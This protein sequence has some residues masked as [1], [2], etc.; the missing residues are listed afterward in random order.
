MTLLSSNQIGLSN[1]H[2]CI[3]LS[4]KGNCTNFRLR[5]VRGRLQ[6][7]E[8]NIHMLIPGVNITIVCIK[9]YIVPK[10]LAKFIKHLFYKCFVPVRLFLSKNRLWTSQEKL[11]SLSLLY[12]LNSFREACKDYCS[13]E[14]GS[15]F[16]QYSN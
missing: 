12:F 13:V 11:S 5:G 7:L 9:L 6:S 10:L 15:P 16:K 4:L 8:R 2:F 3:V 1:S 14:Q